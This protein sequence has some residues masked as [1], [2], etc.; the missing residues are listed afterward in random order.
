MGH[1]SLSI[2]CGLARKCAASRGVGIRTAT[3]PLTPGFHWISFNLVVVGFGMTTPH[4][5]TLAR[6]LSR[7]SVIVTATCLRNR[8]VQHHTLSPLSVI[9]AARVSRC[10]C[11]CWRFL[12]THVVVFNFRVPKNLPIGKLWRVKSL[13]Q[14]QTSQCQYETYDSGQLTYAD[15]HVVF[16]AEIRTRSP[17]TSNG[18]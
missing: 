13:P 7:C 18:G 12:L 16:L 9:C 6:C 10:W 15:H 4:G 17:L 2:I 14:E 8:M 1:C 3:V 11:W 5:V